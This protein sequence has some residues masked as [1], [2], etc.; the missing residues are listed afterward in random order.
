[1]SLIK[2][3]KLFEEEFEDLLEYPIDIDKEFKE[4]IPFN[5]MNVLML[6]GLIKVEYDLDVTVEDVN[7][8]ISFKS[9]YEKFIQPVA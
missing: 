6:L 9:F 5:S 4:I 2:F 1:M 7:E 3:V 8:N